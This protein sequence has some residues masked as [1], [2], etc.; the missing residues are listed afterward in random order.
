MQYFRKLIT[1]RRLAVLI[2][3]GMLLR[4]LIATGYMLDTNPTDGNLLSITI[5]EGPAGI[6]AIAGLSEQQQHHEHHHE[7]SSEDHDHAAQDHAFSACSFWSSSSNSLL[8]DLP[9]F[10]IQDYIFSE[11]VLVY[12]NRFIHRF[13]NNTRLARA[14][15]SLS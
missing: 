14:P 15:P 5:C 3:V 4:S 1:N 10:D 12:Q 8:A 13:S 6:N 9:I 11:E 2:A 7:H